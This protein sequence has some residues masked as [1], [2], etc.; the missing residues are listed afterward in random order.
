MPRESRIPHRGRLPE[1]RARRWRESGRLPSTGGQRCPCDGVHTSSLIST[2]P[3]YPFSLDRSF[4]ATITAMT[5]ERWQVDTLPQIALEN[6]PQ[7][8][9]GSHDPEAR[10]F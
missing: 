4:V 2:K 9:I 1:Y 10:E 6:L 8:F 7:V 5:S 3:E